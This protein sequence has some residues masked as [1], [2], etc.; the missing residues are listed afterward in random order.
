MAKKTKISDAEWLVMEV[1]W[2]EAPVIA[3]DVVSKLANKTDWSSGTIKTLLR[4]LV[5]KGAVRAKTQG[6]RYLYSP[7]IDRK[8][9]TTGLLR[10]LLD[11]AFDGSAQL[12]MAHLIEE[13][14]LSEQDHQEIRRL[15]D[16]SRQAKTR[17]SGRTQP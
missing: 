15:L 13:G 14:K 16:V 7:K 3:Q 5:A 10:R 2:A 4:R 11:S 17:D 12:M 6:R 9:T 8:A 1:V